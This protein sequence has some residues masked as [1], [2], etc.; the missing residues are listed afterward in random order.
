MVE[1]QQ[2]IQNLKDQNEVGRLKQ[3]VEQSKTPIVNEALL[4]GGY[5]TDKQVSD[6]QNMVKARDQ[7]ILKLREKEIKHK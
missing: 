4:M 2:E 6:L 1:Y 5:G 7:D 3:I